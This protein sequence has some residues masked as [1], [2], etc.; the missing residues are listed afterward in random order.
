MSAVRE[1]RQL[2]EGMVEEGRSQL[3]QLKQE[4]QPLAKQVMVMVM[5]MVMVASDSILPL[6]DCG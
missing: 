3:M 2:L 1:E 5:V 6:P 4:I